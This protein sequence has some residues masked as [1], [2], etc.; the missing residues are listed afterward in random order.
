[1][2]RSEYRLLLPPIVV[3]SN[4]MSRYPLVTHYE[5]LAR[6]EDVA[7]APKGPARTGGVAEDTPSAKDGSRAAEEASREA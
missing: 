2:T 6:S 5:D 3:C 7:R 1:M 4:M